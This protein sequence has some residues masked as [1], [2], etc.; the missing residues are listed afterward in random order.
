MPLDLNIKYYHASDQEWENLKG[1]QKDPYTG[2]SQ[3]AFLIYLVKQDLTY[4]A[5]LHT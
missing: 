1:E 4:Y 5:F 3:E 2:M